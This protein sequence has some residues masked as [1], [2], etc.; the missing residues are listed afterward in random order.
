MIIKGL[1]G[2]LV[3][4]ANQENKPV[5]SHSGAAAGL[6][7]CFN[8]ASRRGCAAAKRAAFDMML[9]VKE[10]A[11]RAFPGGDESIVIGLGIPG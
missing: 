11:S 7:R 3:V 1:Y 8:Q 6:R 4:F 10:S 9:R 5:G 2:M